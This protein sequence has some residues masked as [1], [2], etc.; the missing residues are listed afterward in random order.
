MTLTRVYYNLHK[1]KLSIQ[2]KQINASG[3]LVWKVVRH[4]NLIIL[5]NVRFKVSES[6]RQRV[7]KEKKKNVHAF[8][9][10]NEC[11]DP[12]VIEDGKIFYN[13]YKFSSFVDEKLN[14]VDSAPKVC[15]QGNKEGYSI[16]KSRF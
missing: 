15:I 8:V 7:I 10:G 4:S 13:P 11:N 16:L 2:Q 6:G 9:I 3:K 14:P 1:R 12:M 5:E